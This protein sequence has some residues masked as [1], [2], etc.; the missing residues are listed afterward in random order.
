MQISRFSPFG[1]LKFSLTVQN[2]Q[3]D[4]AGEKN[5]KKNKNLSQ[6]MNK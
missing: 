3:N 5:K 2:K 1:S 6:P 4:I